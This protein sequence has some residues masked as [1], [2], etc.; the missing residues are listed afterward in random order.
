MLGSVARK[1]RIFGFDTLYIKDIHDDDVLKIGITHNRVILTCDKQLF[2][3]MIKTGAHGALLQG[4]D[5]F[6]D[7]VHALAKYGISSLSFDTLNSR[8]STC[9]GLLTKKK[10]ID[11]K[12]YVPHNVT[13]WHKE[14]FICVDCDKIYWEGSHLTRI[15]ALA[16]K[17]DI[18]IKELKGMNVNK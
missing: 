7:I 15:R 4:Y 10:P 17:M 11:V 16:R 9:N 2:K 5:D 18:K 1:L 6:E 12:K 3:R 14:F 13:K 8:C